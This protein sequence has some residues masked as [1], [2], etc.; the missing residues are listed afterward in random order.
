MQRH[1]IIET[2]GRDYL[3]V[4]IENDEYSYVVAAGSKAK[5]EKKVGHPV[6]HFKIDLRFES[7]DTVVLV[8]TKQNFV[9]EDSKQLKAYLEDERALHPGKKVICMLANTNNDNV[10][11]WKSF[12]DDDYLLKDES[13][14][15]RMAHYMKLF[16]INKSNDR[17]TV[18]KN[19]Y[20]LNELL[21]KKD[22][23][24]KLRSQFVGTCLLY[25]KDILNP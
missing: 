24:E 25:I 17:E 10:K 8:E 19:T 22:I 6:K 14:I 23:D 12:V 21:H 1:D 15:D 9:E 11:V 18:L 20:A 16:R 2:I 3:T 4:N 13:T 7:D 5:L